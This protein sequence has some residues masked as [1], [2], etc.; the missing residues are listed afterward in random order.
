MNFTPERAHYYKWMAW[1]TNTLQATLVVYFYPERWVDDGNAEG[2]RQVKA[3]AEAK[4]APMLDQLD[5]QLA[6]HGGPWLLG[7][8]YSALDPFA[9][10]LCRW[11][12][13]F[14]RPARALPHIGPYRQRML[15]R[16]AVRRAMATEGLREPWV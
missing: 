3:H 16:P 8:S 1:L 2:A 4:V 7:A 14:A 13:G 6:S 5:A 11:T 12:R 9:F 15:E 10:M